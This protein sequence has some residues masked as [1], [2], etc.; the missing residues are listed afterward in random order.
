MQTRFAAR[1]WLAITSMAVVASACAAPVATAPPF[2]GGSPA[3]FAAVASV[4]SDPAATASPLPSGKVLAST[5]YHYQLVYPEDWEGVEVLGTGGVH[6]DEPGVDTYHGKHGYILSVVG[7]DGVPALAGWTCSIDRHLEVDH[8]LTP[9]LNETLTVAGVPAQ[10]T[11]FHLVIAPYVI[12]YLNVKIVRDGEGLTLSLESTNKDDAMD[13][14]V[15]D[16]L[17]AGLELT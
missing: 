3:T 6:P 17:L 12:H 14:V 15:L 10:L 1:R 11:G 7:Q 4:P 9:D 2:L 5:R 16:G 8:K 13:R